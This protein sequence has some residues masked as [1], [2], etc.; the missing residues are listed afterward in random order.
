MGRP[1]YDG[2]GEPTIKDSSPSSTKAKA[3]IPQE[4]VL[5]SVSRRPRGVVTT[6]VVHRS[7]RWG[8]LSTNGGFLHDLSQGP[9]GD[10]KRHKRMGWVIAVQTDVLRVCIDGLKCALATSFLLVHLPNPL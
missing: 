8:S 10:E 1:E 3:T 4:A 5:Q 9:L 6:G 2:P 7:M